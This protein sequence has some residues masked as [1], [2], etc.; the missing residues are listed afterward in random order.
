MAKKT[1]AGAIPVKRTMNLYYKP[2]RT[3]GPATAAL[4]ILFGL[5][6]LLAAAKVGIYDRLEQLRFARQKLAF[7]EAEEQQYAQQ[8]SDYGE[9]LHRYHL[10]AATE[11]EQTTVDRLKVLDLVDAHIGSRAELLSVSI[12]QDSVAVRMRGVTLG[13]AAEILRDLRSDP[14][15]SFAAVDTAATEDGAKA[16]PSQLITASVTI[17]LVKEGE[18]S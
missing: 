12:A 13:E 6:L 1:K 7:V 17:T 3:T 5:T 15:V 9:V 8:L 11:A 16:D 14:L 10:Y 18:G 4:Y 2:D